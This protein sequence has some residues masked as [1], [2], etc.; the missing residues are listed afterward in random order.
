MTTT[1]HTI[2]AKQSAF[3]AR[4]FEQKDTGFNAEAIQA[5]IDHL[6]EMSKQEASDLISALLAKPD[7]ANS[8][9]APKPVKDNYGIPNAEDL[10]TGRYA[11][12]NADGELT[13]YR[14]WRGTK[15]PDYVKLYLQHGPDETEVP[16]GKGFVTITKEIAKNPG[17][18]AIRY[19]H[20]IGQCSVC[21]KRLTNRVSRSLGIGP[22][23]GGRFWGEEFKAVVRGAREQI[24]AQGLD[25]DG[26][27][28]DGEEVVHYD[29]ANGPTSYETRDVVAE[30][31][32]FATTQEATPAQTHERDVEGLLKMSTVL[33]DMERRSDAEIQSI[34]AYGERLLE[35]RAFA[36]REAEQERAA[37]TRKMNDQTFLGR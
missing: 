35:K 33:G 17:A 18:A 1:S 29:I 26:N 31:N 2:T 16:F 23:C 30:N 25:P 32:P 8:N 36:Q 11:I 10:P 4:L 24:K 3:I 37:Y 20:E 21:A 5:I 14:V 27:V 19:G 13:F 22:V 28:E 9:D 15:N 6:P 7:K 12:D 34:I